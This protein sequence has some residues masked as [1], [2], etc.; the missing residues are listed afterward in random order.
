[1]H[2]GSYPPSYLASLLEQGDG[3]LNAE[4]EFVSKWTAGILY[5]GGADTVL[6]VETLL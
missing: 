6:P 3:K 2:R 5:L 4:E 1:M